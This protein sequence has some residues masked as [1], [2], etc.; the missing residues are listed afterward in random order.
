MEADHGLRLPPR[1]GNMSVNKKKAER[2]SAEEPVIRVVH[3]AIDWYSR[4]MGTG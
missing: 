4:F 1:V 3:D 2:Y